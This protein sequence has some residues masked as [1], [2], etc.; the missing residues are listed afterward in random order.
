MRPVNRG[1]G[2]GVNNGFVHLQTDVRRNNM[3][4][5]ILADGIVCLRWAFYGFTVLPDCAKKERM[6]STH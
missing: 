5:S 3:M 1:I 2:A 6:F 4:R